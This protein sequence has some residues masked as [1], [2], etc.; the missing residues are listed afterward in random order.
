MSRQQ[1]EIARLFQAQLYINSSETGFKLTFGGGGSL[2]N[3]QWVLTAAH[4]IQ[5][6][7]S[8]LELLT[9]VLGEHNYKLDFET[10]ER[11]FRVEAAHMHPAFEPFS[12]FGL[13]KLAEEVQ[14]TTY[15]LIRPIC[16]PGPSDRD[17]D[18]GRRAFVSG[19]G[20]GR[21]HTLRHAINISYKRFLCTKYS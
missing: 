4:C 20:L 9:V 19:W 1:D 17:H 8:Q 3:S 5:P 21:V 16:L 7:K 18:L 11:Q 2:L 10:K 12:E 6:F 13:L 14:F 15:P